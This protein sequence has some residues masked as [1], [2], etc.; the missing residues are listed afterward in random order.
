MSLLWF[1]NWTQRH[2]VILVPCTLSVSL[3]VLFLVAYL[4][5]EV[6]VVQLVVSE[7]QM[8]GTMLMFAL[9]AGYLVLCML[10]QHRRTLEV[11]DVIATLSSQNGSNPQAQQLEDGVREK[12]NRISNWGVP[13]L[14]IGAA[15]GTYQNV[16]IVSI[17][18]QQQAAT[19]MDTVYILSGS[20]IWFLIALI[21]CWRIPASMSLSRLSQSVP[22]NLY[23]LHQLKPLSRISTTD[24]LLVA[25]AMALMPLQSLDAEFRVNNYSAGA[26]VGVLSA[27]ALFF[28][29]L[30]GIRKNICNT[31]ARRLEELQSELLAIDYSDTQRKELVSAHIDRIGNI[32]N[33]PVDTRMM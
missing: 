1:F 29:P 12:L 32:A 30:L 18:W 17:M 25:G 28:L 24:V 6:A 26:L 14:C 31:K 16:A 22:I 27:I 10:L 15:Y 2:S 3:F 13:I 4:F 20:L 33:W 8:M 19:F 9:L 23:A 11:L 7:R 5:N 21:L